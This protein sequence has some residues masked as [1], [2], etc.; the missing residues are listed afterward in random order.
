[1]LEQCPTCGMR[2]ERDEG[3]FLGAWVINY[4]AVA[5]V[6]FAVLIGVIAVEATGHPR[7]VVPVVSGGMAAAVVTP[8]VAYPW[9]RTLWV[10][11]ELVMRPLEPREI[12]AADQA[13]GA[14]GA[15][16]TRLK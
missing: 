3:F 16:R 5:L 10:A 13:R 2:F 6:I 12:A 14:G 9:S 15:H 7:A 4:A 8:I 1:M 11:I